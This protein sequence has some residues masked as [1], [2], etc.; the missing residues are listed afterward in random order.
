[1][2]MAGSHK[3][4]S[5]KLIHHSDRGL[6]YCSDQYQE[7]LG[8]QRIECSMTEKYDPYENAV[9]ERINGTLKREFLLET[10]H[11]R[12]DVMKELVR[13]SVEIYNHKRPHYWSYYLTPNQMHQ[14][15]E[16]KMRTYKSKK[17][18]DDVILE[19]N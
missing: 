11:L 13:G 1:M 16:M 7:L 18:K 4:T 6:Q 19:L 15:S 9:A 5:H 17:L 3:K 10:S 2:E 12:L 8:N 14:Q